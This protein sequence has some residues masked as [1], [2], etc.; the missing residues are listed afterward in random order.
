MPDLRP[1][2]LR[3]LEQKYLDTGNPLF[4]WEALDYALATGACVPGWLRGF[5]SKTASAILSADMDVLSHPGAGKK[6][7]QNLKDALGLSCLEYKDYR[8]FD[9]EFR[10][11]Q[12]VVEM[13]S[14][15][16]NVGAALDAASEACNVSRKQMERAYYR[17]RKIA[18]PE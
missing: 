15:S 4:A 17:I 2:L 11:Y 6:L 3:F 1:H 12:T 16:P 14:E 9:V 5:L 7:A 18:D 8:R 13:L 10:R